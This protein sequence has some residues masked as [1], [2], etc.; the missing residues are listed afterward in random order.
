MNEQSNGRMN[1]WIIQR[2]KEWMNGRTNDWMK[3]EWLID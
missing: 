2:Q 3:I 1:D